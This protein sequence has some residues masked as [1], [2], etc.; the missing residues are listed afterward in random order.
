MKYLHSYVLFSFMILS[1]VSSYSQPLDVEN[2][3]RVVGSIGLG[4]G[5]KSVQISGSYAYVT[6]EFP[7]TVKTIDI[8]NPT[9]PTLV[10]NLTTGLSPKSM[11]LSGQYL[12][13]VDIG[14]DKLRII[15]I[16][17][18]GL[19]TVVSTIM[20]GT[21]PSS[22]FVEGKYAY[23]VDEGDDDFKIIDISKSALPVVVDTLALSFAPRGVFVCGKFAYVVDGGTEDLKIINI[24]D[25]DVP[26][27]V[28][29]VLIGSIPQSV[30]VSGQ[31]AYVVSF[32]SND[33]K[34]IDISNSTS[35][36]VK[37]TVTI[38]SL[39]G[40]VYVSGRY[41]YVVDEG[42]GKLLIID[43]SNP[44]APTKV[45]SLTIGISPQ[46]IQVSGRYAYVVDDGS[47]DL[48]VI[49]ISGIETRASIIHSLDA[50]K[51]QVKNDIIAGGR[52]Q[53]KRSINVG[54]GGIYSD[55]SIRMA[56]HLDI[57]NGTNGNAGLRINASDD[58]ISS[59]KLFEGNGFGFELEYDGNDDL[60]YLY[61]RKFSGNEAVRMTWQKNGNVGIGTTNP[62]S[63]L[64]VS[65]G[66][67]R[68]AG[69]S[70]IDDGT[71]L[72]VPD[73]VFQKSYTI[74]PL[75]EVEQYIADYNHLEGFPSMYD[76][77][78]WAAMSMQARDMK[79]LEKIEEL[80]LYVIEQKKMI[81]FQKDENTKMINKLNKL[82][83]SVNKLLVLQE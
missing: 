25:P 71:T 30:F 41:A 26:V 19:P 46:S 55:G 62:S 72:N 34:V 73:Y 69:G 64:E 3:I 44:S 61:S 56:G 74:T 28:G 12:Y 7:G 48:K 9:T 38:G 54:A 78:G 6:E 50:G 43:V 29:S 35:P 37:G 49:D 24:S 59:L 20:I 75:E 31:H 51:I 14:D 42:T 58:E 32:G 65:G 52:L 36:I 21:F 2:K 76:T 5:A 27:I 70:F 81:N 53:V 83:T 45:D 17:D 11:F 77:L 82:E 4:F 47:N 68:V 15:D 10:N 40:D 63:K 16:S 13:T 57:L 8:S 23:V 67:I 79:M 18:P 80:T 39:P 66:D 1:T 60:L 33:L 22:I